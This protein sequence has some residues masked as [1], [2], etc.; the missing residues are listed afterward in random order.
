[1]LLPLNLKGT[2]S[3][4]QDEHASCDEAVIIL[5]HAYLFHSKTNERRRGISGQHEVVVEVVC[6]VTVIWDGVGVE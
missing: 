5:Q 2:L 3:S 4:C 1:M 6:A